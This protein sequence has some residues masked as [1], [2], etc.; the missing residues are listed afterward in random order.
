M[1]RGVVLLLGAAALSGQTPVPKLTETYRHYCFDFNWVDKLD[2][3]GKPLSDY[4]KLSAEEQIRALE[5]MHANSLMVFTMSISG[6]TFFDSKVG[7]RHPR[8]NYD[9]LKEMVR[10]GHQR[11]IAME[12]YVPTAWADRVIQKSPSWAIRKPDGSLL[13]SLYGG[14]HPD[15]NSPAAGWYASLLRELFPAYGA[16]GFFADGISMLRYGQSEYTVKKFRAEMGREY[17]K[18][19]ETDPDWRATMRWEVEQVRKYWRMIRETI[20]QQD[21]KVEMTFNGPGP[22]IQAPYEEWAPMPP[23]LNLEADYAFTEAGS[24]GEFATWTRG[25]SWPRPFKV[26]FLNAYSILD[27]FDA[28]E[29]RARMGRTLAEGGQPYR[30]DQTSVDGAANAH[31]VRC[32]SEMFAEVKAKE[33]YVVGAEPVKYAAVVSSEPTMLYRGRADDS[34]HGKDLVGAL[35]ALDALHI[36][37]DVLA[38]WNLKPEILSG[39][40]LVILPNVACMTNA[41]AAAVREY[42]R[43]GGSVLATAET[44]L[45][46]E[47]GAPRKEFALADVL[48][49]KLDETLT[50]ATQKGDRKRPIHLLP[51]PGGHP[52]FAGMPATEL[53]LPGDSVFALAAEGQPAAALIEDAGTPRN[54][55]YRVTRR[56]AVHVNTFGKGRSVYICGSL[57]ARTYHQ[58]RPGVYWPDGLIRNAA[59][60]LAPDAPWHVTAPARVWVGLNRQAGR[61]RHILHV[62]NWQTDMPAQVEFRLPAGSPVGTRVKVVWPEAARLT[63]TVRDG[64][65]V[66]TLRD[67]GPHGMVSFE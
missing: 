18:S 2:R 16:E 46:D 51:R 19:L 44:S 23:S 36:P 15:I 55:P 57:F 42:V 30:Y 26:T 33:P 35:R 64:E 49:V 39:Y 11:G 1:L 43:S 6:Y 13:T 37:H 12:L 21:P 62:V 20:H 38:D 50:N 27:P 47:N 67:A 9:Y 56:A 7:E 8:L 52:V 24:G 14:Y 3:A 40:S 45:F 48:G 53:L 54:S 41:Q 63:G 4:S 66:Y 60:W 32:W 17:P 5:E 34:S 28:D 61:K 29:I 10:L 31:F 25:V 59:H 22:M 65:R 58:R